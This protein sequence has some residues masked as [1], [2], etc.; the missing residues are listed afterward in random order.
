LDRLFL[1]QRTRAGNRACFRE[2]GDFVAHRDT[3]EKGLVTQS[4]RDIFTSLDVWSLGLR[5]RRPSLADIARA[6][7][8]NL[9]LASDEQLKSGCGCQHQTARKRLQRALEKV[10]RN[11]KPT[12]AEFKVLNYLGNRFIWKPAFTA[13]QL[14]VEFNEVLTQ[15]GII[16]KADSAALVNAKVFLTLYALAVM[17]GS[18]I[19][20]ENG[21]KARLFAG[22]ANHER[23]LEVKV[24][25]AFNEL[26]KPVLAPICLFLTELSAENHC[27][28]ELLVSPTPTVPSH[29]EFPI[30]VGANGHLGRID[31]EPVKD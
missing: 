18:S 9:R 26:S 20:L 19:I 14:F 4:G 5:G 1:G 7:H 16:G 29:W 21:E 25:I 13:D 8:A 3:R 23:R 31:R 28:R 2:I 24:D 22:Y 15:N 17:H 11:E 6:G 30:D 12:D 27:D 10:E